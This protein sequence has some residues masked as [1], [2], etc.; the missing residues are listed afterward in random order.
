VVPVPNESRLRYLAWIEDNRRKVDQLTGG[1]VAYIHMP[2]TSL[3]GY[4]SFT[5]YFY[6]QV[7]K[8]AAIIDERFNHGGHLATDI[9][10]YLQRRLMSVA[11]YRDGAD[12]NQPFG[13]IFGPKV[14]IINE[15]AGS[16]GDAMPW[17]FKRAG[18]GKLVGERTWG[19]LIGLSGFPDLMDG[20]SVTAPNA[21]IWNPNGQFDV[22]NRGITP[23]IEVQL[24]PAAVR[25]GHDPQLERAI[26][27]VMEEL[28]KNP[29]AQ[30]KRPPYPNYHPK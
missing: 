30:P 25:Q 1:R 23:D 24:D 27:V 17:Y 26:Q 12:S 9:I 11:S 19:G 14:M 5:R 29:P 20:G 7:G 4:Q 6:A 28:Q 13:A 2:D 16:G 8:D 3:G 18:V 22:E 10:E 15:F 21:A